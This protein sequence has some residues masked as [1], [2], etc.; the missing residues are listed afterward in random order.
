MNYN[1]RIE[2]LEYYYKKEEAYFET[3]S[4]VKVEN[5]EII[6]NNKGDNKF[7]NK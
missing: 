3:D 4:E 2:D 5:N 6:D 7:R 1:S